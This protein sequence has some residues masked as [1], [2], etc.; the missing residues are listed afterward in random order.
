MSG[1]ISPPLTGSSIVVKL[2]LLSLAYVKI[3]KAFL[4]NLNQIISMEF[5]IL[6]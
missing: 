4:I 3:C 5:C 1:G 6:T 2:V